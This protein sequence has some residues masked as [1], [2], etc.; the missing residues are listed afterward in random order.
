MALPL[1]S[2]FGVEIEAMIVDAVT[3]NVRPI[4]DELLAAVAGE[5][6]SE[7]EA[8]DIAW[9]NELALH[10]IEFKTNGPAVDLESLPAKFSESFHRANAALAPLGARLMPTAMH[11]WMNPHSELKLWPHEYNAVY[12][13]YNRI[14]N[15]QGHGWANLQ[16]VHLNLPFAND[17][18]FG[19]LHAAIRLLLPLIPALSA[20][21]PIADGKVQ[22]ALD[23]R[24]EVY[25]TNSRR[26]PSLT[27]YVVPEPVYTEADYDREIFQRLYRD[28]A[29]FDTDQIMQQPFLNSRGA[30]ARFDRG[31]IEI[32]IVDSQECPSADL[33]I[34]AFQVAVLKALTAQRWSIVEEQAAFETSELSALLLAV[35]KDGEQ[36]VI[37]DP[38]FL[39][40]FGIDARRCSAGDVCR[41]LIQELKL[42]CSRW[43][44]ELQTITTQGPLSRR[45]LKAIGQQP[46]RTMHAVYS[47][48]C[49]CLAED[50]MFV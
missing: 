28:I 34:V 39:R 21:S 13:S 46:E 30:I 43:A 11:P 36:A 45:I 19:Q 6:V 38:A 27:G 24:L 15:C 23:Y 49:N 22:A 17:A 4:A 18:E 42:D 44:N 25:R 7:F 2:G 10:V 37:E 12:E 1:F 26:V 5:V 8:G 32:R 41:H 9:S 35:I 40:Q 50:R 47:E 16:S 20:S 14:F 3:L 29:P 33:A 31:A 48:L